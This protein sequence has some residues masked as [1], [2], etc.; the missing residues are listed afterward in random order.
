MATSLNV[1]LVA[2]P[3]AGISTLHGIYDVLNGFGLSRGV[4]DAIPE[5]PPFHVEIVS[6]DGEPLVLASGLITPVH[7]SILDSTKT[8]DVIIVPSVVVGESGWEV[9]RYAELVQWLRVAHDDGALLCSACSGVFLLAETGLLDGQAVTLHW[10]YS[11]EF[12]RVFPNLILHPDKA[13]VVSGERQQFV[14]SGASTSWHD[15]VLY[16]IARTVGRTVAQAIANVFALQWHRDGLGP[17]IVFNGRID[18]EDSAIAEAQKWLNSN[19]ASADPIVEAIGRS[20][21]AERTFMRR[22]REATKHT[23][24]AYVQLLRVEDAKRRLERTDMSIETIAWQ[25]GYE[26]AAFFRRLFKRVTAVTP[27]H[28][29]RRFGIPPPAA[30]NSRT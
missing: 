5:E 15:L 24:L 30:T 3:E 13:L 6:T 21:L 7:R 1:S 26:D 12:A 16:L 4:V 2:I 8:P 25:V 14:S 22:F 19:Y 28:Y 27:G 23:P 29:R 11:T 17:Y 18:H 9:G 20:G 10:M